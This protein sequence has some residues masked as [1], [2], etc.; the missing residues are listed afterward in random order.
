MNK[1][2]CFVLQYNTEAMALVLQLQNEQY[3][4]VCLSVVH[5]NSS[6]YFS[7]ITNGYEIVKKINWGSESENPKILNSFRNWFFFFFRNWT[8]HSNLLID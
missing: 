7:S 2:C 6:G 4:F 5:Q 1:S 3:F 8:V